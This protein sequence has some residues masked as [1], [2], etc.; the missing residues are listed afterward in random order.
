[1]SEEEKNIFLRTSNEI[2]WLSYNTQN[3]EEQIA[4]EKIEK[5]LEFKNRINK[6]NNIQTLAEAKNLSQQIMPVAQ[7]L[8]QF[9]IGDALC[10]IVNK[11][12]MFRI[13]LDSETEFISYDFV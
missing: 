8:S 2:D 4:K 12:N 5:Y 3:T 1:M 10:V 9:R 11:P 13:S 6:F 7:E